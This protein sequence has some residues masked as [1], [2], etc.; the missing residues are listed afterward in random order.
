MSRV[1]PPIGFHGDTYLLKLVDRLA[2]KV[3]V[4]I[5]TGTNIAATMSYFSK[6]F[7]NVQCFGCE[8]SVEQHKRAVANAK[9]S[10]VKIFNETSQRFMERLKA[11]DYLYNKSTLFWLDAH[12]RGFEWPLRKEVAYFTSRFLKGYILIDDFM[13]PDRK[14]FQYDRYGNQVCCFN[15]I[16]DYISKDVKYRLYYPKYTEH[17]SK[18]HPLVGWGLIQF[19]SRKL[20]EP[21][22]DLTKEYKFIQLLQPFV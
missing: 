12:G 8:P 17:T 5:E 22:E 1:Y 2:K 18:Y 21:L 11:C 6:R 15:F 20:N 4:F 19:K 13:I 7:A 9:F 16:K 3:D 14:E 10:N